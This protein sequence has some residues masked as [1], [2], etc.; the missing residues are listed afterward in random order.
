MR[1]HALYPV[2]GS[3]QY[4]KDMQLWDHS[5]RRVT[6]VVSRLKH[7]MFKEKLRELGLVNMEKEAVE[8]IATYR[9]LGECREN[10]ATLL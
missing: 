5:S 2:L 6:K 8:D 3:L 9:V 10:R 1:P 4:K 7:R